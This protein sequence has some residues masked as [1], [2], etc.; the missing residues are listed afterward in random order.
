M[1]SI[2]AV[3]AAL[4]AI[5]GCGRAPL[6]PES[7][8][9]E[10]IVENPHGS[11]F[12]VGQIAGDRHTEIVGRVSDRTWRA[13]L[14]EGVYEIGVHADG[15]RVGLPAPLLRDLVQGGRLTVRIPPLAAESED[16]AWIPEGHALIGDVL[17]IGQEDERPAHLVDLGEFW[18]GRREVTNAEYAAFLNEAAA[19]VDESWL[20]FDSKKCL[21]KRDEVTAKWTTT[22]PSMPVVTVSLAGAQAYCAWLTRRTGVRH[23]LPTEAE[24]EKSAR[25]PRST[26]YD[27]GNVFR[28]LA[29]NQESGRL[30][31]GGAFE[32]RGFGLF[33]MTGNAFEWVADEYDGGAYRARAGSVARNPLV[34]AGSAGGDPPYQVLRGGSFVLDG[35]YLRNSFRM[36]QRPSVR[37]DD[38]GFR[39]VRESAPGPRKD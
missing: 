27:Y 1:R 37:T 28:R 16:W 31:E 17:G 9:V 7:P 4:V 19:A 24:W 11:A 2:A 30:R 38:I 12:D 10:L 39:V 6:G 34:R 13:S 20:A 22:A 14:R 8:T 26:I 25:G 18:I 15:R 33:D 36:K 3:F 21:V 29:A 32:A 23:R 35:M 5:A